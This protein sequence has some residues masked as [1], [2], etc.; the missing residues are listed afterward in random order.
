MRMIVK[1]E[2]ERA[3]RLGDENGKGDDDDDTK[4]KNETR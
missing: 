1:M 4:V 3:K 2:R